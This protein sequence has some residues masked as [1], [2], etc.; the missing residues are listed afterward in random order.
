MQQ[1]VGWCFPVLCPPWRLWPTSSRCPNDVVGVIAHE[2]LQYNSCNILYQKDI[3]L[4]Y[5]YKLLE[6]PLLR[7]GCH[8]I[9]VNGRDSYTRHLCCLG[10]VSCSTVCSARGIIK[11]GKGRRSMWVHILSVVCFWTVRFLFL[12]RSVVRS[13]PGSHLIFFTTWRSVFSG[14]CPW[15]FF[16]SCV[17]LTWRLILSLSTLVSATVVSY[18]RLPTS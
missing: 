2:V 8:S 13:L 6:R 7:R 12:F 15:L 10:G 16:S 18:W 1:V 14:I 5:P 17:S 4:R 11:Q 9:Y 3:N